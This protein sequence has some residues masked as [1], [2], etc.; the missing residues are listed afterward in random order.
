M[1]IRRFSDVVFVIKSAGKRA[2]DQGGG[3]LPKREARGPAEHPLSGRHDTAIN[4]SARE[5]ARDVSEARGG[6]GYK[7][8]QQKD[9]FF[10]EIALR[11]DIR[12]RF[13]QYPYIA[14]VLTELTEL[15]HP[16]IWSLR[17]ARS[18]GS[19]SVH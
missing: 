12:F 9:S 5:R 6:Y 4:A 16:T 14:K 18:S 17:C 8:L 15:P 2:Q 10:Y 11:V 3:H 19:C 13:S 1:R 7:S